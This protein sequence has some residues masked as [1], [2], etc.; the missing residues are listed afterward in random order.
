MIDKGFYSAFSYI[1]DIPNPSNPQKLGYCSTSDY[2][3]SSYLYVADCYVGL[4]IINT[5]IR[6]RKDKNSTTLLVNLSKIRRRLFT[7]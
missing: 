2:A 3:S 6:K 5:G 7:L 4:Q 1:L